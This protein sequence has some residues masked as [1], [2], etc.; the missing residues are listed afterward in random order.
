[1]TVMMPWG[2]GRATKHRVQAP[3]P[4]ARTELDPVSQLTR[5]YDVQGVLVDMSREGTSRAYLTVTMS[6]PEDG[7]QNAPQGGDDTKNDEDSD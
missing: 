6:R 7:S 1:M 4:Y 2:L 3:L 5:F